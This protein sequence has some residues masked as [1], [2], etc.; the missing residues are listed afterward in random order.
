MADI[1]S[2]LRA[3]EGANTPKR[4][5]G[6]GVGSGLGK[7]AGH[8]Q[9]GQ[10]ARHPGN[11]SKRQF[12]GGQTTYQRR[13]P[14]RGFFNPFSL[15]VATVNV[16]E[17]ERFEPG[18]RVDE[19]ALRA[20]R[21]VRGRFDRIKVLGEGELTKPLTVSVHAFSASAKDKIE[22]A[23]G[24]AVA[25]VPAAEAQPEAQPEQPSA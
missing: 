21:L 7:T 9:K 6:R 24:H 15:V 16:G 10:K 25:I 19:Q 14:K 20:A 12:E 23:G 3:P 1:L 11:F 8:G 2:R 22:R 5:V 18:A 17:L 4:R 13:L